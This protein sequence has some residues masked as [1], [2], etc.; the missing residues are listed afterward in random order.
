MKAREEYDLGNGE[1][2]L[3]GFFF[4]VGVKVHKR[5]TDSA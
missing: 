3:S 2:F 4:R 5:S 1:I